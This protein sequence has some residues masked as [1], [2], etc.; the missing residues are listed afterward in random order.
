MLLRS[1][2]MVFT[3]IL[4]KIFVKRKLY[5]HHVV[6]MIIVGIGLTVVAVLAYVYN[7]KDIIED[8]ELEPAESTNNS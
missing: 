3:G 6:A 8:D 7:E 2:L 4:S 1:S 5:L